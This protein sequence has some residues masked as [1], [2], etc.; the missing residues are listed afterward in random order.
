M[1][2]DSIEINGG[3]LKKPQGGSAFRYTID[4]NN[5]R[6]PIPNI[7]TKLLQLFVDDSKRRDAL[8]N[9][10]IIIGNNEKKETIPGQATVTIEELERGLPQE[11]SNYYLESIKKLNELGKSYKSK[12][13]EEKY[14]CKKLKNFKRVNWSV[15]FDE[16]AKKHNIIINSPTKQFIK[17]NYEH[18]INIRK[19]NQSYNKPLKER[20]YLEDKKEYA[21]KFN[22][23]VDDIKL[24]GSQ[25]TELQNVLKY[26]EEAVTKYPRLMH[27]VLEWPLFTLMPK[28]STDILIFCE[29]SEYDRMLKRQKGYF[30]K[31][32]CFSTP[33]TQ[34]TAWLIYPKGESWCKESGIKFFQELFLDINSILNCNWEL[35]LHSYGLT[36]SHGN[37]H[38]YL[39]DGWDRLFDDDYSPFFDED[40][41]RNG[42][43]NCYYITDVFFESVR[44][45]KY[46]LN[47]STNELTTDNNNQEKPE[48]RY[49]IDFRSVHWFGKDY[50]F[51]PNQAA[52]VKILWEAWENETPDVGGDTLA[53]VIES[54]SKRARDIF[55]GH[56]ALNSMICQ[57]QTKGTYR[58]VKP[59]KT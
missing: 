20:I 55:K 2:Q 39:Y 14:L 30:I 9:E 21:T 40:G 5:I 47:K 22:T 6:Q 53:V 19:K 25:K 4:F 49:S 35:L 15:E 58:L 54:D 27:V 23:I 10:W 26:F 45:C 38:H 37:N 32:S 12:L 16:D 29:S 7:E 33:E 42:L 1:N 34:S 46:L 44:L 3:E 31:D 57:G 28:L 50:T 41:W 18:I 36:I 56:P 8:P 59:E 24:N 43:Y 13:E 52:A 51:T 48:A 11:I 17:E